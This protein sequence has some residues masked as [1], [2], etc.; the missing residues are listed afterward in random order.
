MDIYKKIDM[1]FSG[2]AEEK[3]VWARE[4]LEELQEIKTLLQEDKVQKKQSIRAYHQDGLY[5][6]IKGFRL[7][8]RANTL[9]NIYPTFEY[10]ERKL[11]IDF[12]GLLYDKKTTRI[13]PREEAYRVYKYAYNAQKHVNNIA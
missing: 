5:Q 7:S 6:F 9:K 1:I 3:P 13:L 4:I 11:G 12:K 2:E 10:H 8:M